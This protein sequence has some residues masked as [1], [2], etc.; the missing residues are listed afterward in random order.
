MGDSNTKPH[1]SGP[2]EGLRVVELGAV[3]AASFGAR[4]LAEFGAE[5][6]KIEAPDSL[7]PLRYWG[8]A[9]ING[10]ALWWPIQSRNKKLVTIN[11]LRPEGADL[12]VRLCEQS[13]VLIEN[14]RP[15]T[16]ERWG[17][18]PERLAEANPELVIARISGYGQTGPY[19][20][21]PSYAAV[22]EAVGGMRY[23]N[24]WPDRP[25]L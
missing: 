2:L 11:L 8:R 12:L 13:D 25:P 23:I 4:L 1:A 15:G 6:I 14:F 24:G 16:L 9:R 22:A 10:R 18:G 17:V 21:Q 7:D 19:A 20:E 3:V 5:L